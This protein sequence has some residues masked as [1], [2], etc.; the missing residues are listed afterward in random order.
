MQGETNGAQR[1]RAALQVEVVIAVAGVEA[2][3]IG[4]DQAALT[5]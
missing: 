4:G 2:A 1:L 5:Q 3:S